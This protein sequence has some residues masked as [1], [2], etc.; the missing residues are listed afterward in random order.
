[1]VP[2]NTR[3]KCMLANQKWRTSAYLHM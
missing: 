1:M 2:I 3:M